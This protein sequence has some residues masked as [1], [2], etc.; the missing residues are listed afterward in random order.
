MSY[1]NRKQSISP[2]AYLFI[3]PVGVGIAFSVW[4]GLGWLLMIVLHGF[5]MK[6]TF[7]PCVGAIVLLSFIFGGARSKT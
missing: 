4:A 7:W 3:V 1:R 5:G 6:A 2:W